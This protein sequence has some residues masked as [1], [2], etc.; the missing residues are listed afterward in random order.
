[1]QTNTRAIRNI[2]AEAFE[3]TN[4][5]PRVIQAAGKIISE[6]SGDLVDGVMHFAALAKAQGEDEVEEVLNELERGLRRKITRTNEWQI[7][8]RWLITKAKEGEDYRTWILWY[9]S[10]EWRAAKEAWKLIPEQVRNSWPQAFPV[11]SEK[12]QPLEGGGFYG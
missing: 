7:L 2:I 6:K 9:K 12:Q 3:V 11:Q 8:A 10:D 5:D 1:M 4:D